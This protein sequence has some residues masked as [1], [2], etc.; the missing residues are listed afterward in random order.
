MSGKQQQQTTQA[1][2]IADQ[3]AH[4]YRQRNARNSKEQMSVLKQRVP[5]NMPDT[6]VGFN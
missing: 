5:A 1:G 6:G 3:N 2:G 4:S